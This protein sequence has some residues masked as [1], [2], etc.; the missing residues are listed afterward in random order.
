MISRGRVWWPGIA[1]WLVLAA[2]L[3][4][5]QAAKAQNNLPVYN[6]KTKSYFE[7]R[8]DSVLYWQEAN[9][10]AMSLSYKGVRGRLAVVANQET[11]NFLHRSF[12]LEAETWIGLQ[13]WCSFRKLLWVTGKLH[14]RSAFSPW[15]ADWNRPGIAPCEDA[16]TRISGFMPVYYL[17]HSR[18]FRWQAV[19][20]SKGFD[21]YLVEYPTGGE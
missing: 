18:G 8:L 15:A 9:A 19:G 1:L 14:D 2:C 21:R 6:P 11:H 16:A 5:P 13:Y 20:S 17:P 10:K 4:Q 7:L 12:K 3:T